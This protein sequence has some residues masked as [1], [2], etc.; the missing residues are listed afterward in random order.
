MVGVSGFGIKEEAGEGS[1]VVCLGA[2]IFMS[3]VFFRALYYSRIGILGFLRFF[4]R[5]VILVVARFFF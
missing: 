2:G 5:I 4:D 3:F 1:G